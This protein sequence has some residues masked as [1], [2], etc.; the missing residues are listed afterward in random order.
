MTTT[1]ATGG[2]RRLARI[3]A[4]GI[5]ISLA[6]G[7]ARLLH[8]L[9]SGASAAIV[10]VGV[11]I[12]LRVALIY[13]SRSASSAT[14]AK[15]MR[16]VSNVGLAVSAVTVIAAVPH[17]TKHGGSG[18]FFSDAFGQLWALAVLTILAGPVRTIG[19][20]GLVGAGLAGFLAVTGL[21]RLVDRPLVNHFGVTS[22]F[23]V[24]GVVPVTEELFKLLP[25]LLVVLIAIRRT[26]VR[27]SVLDLVLLG[28][29]SGAGFTLFEDASLGRGGAQFGSFPPL[30]WLS[31]GGVHAKV[32]GSGYL[33]VGHLVH[34]ALIALGLG[35]W[36]LY[37]HRIR[38]AW[39]WLLLPIGAA[40]ADHMLNNAMSTGRLSHGTADP[41]LVLTLWGHLSLLLLLAG[42]G[43]LF[44]REGRS[45]GSLKPAKSWVQLTPE[46]AISRGK[47]LAVA[48]RSGNTIT[49]NPDGTVTVTAVDGTVTTTYPGGTSTVQGKDGS[50][51]LHK[52]GGQVINPDGSTD[53]DPSWKPPG[54]LEEDGGHAPG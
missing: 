30:S 45:I 51:T 12:G 39:A 48:Q 41:F 29:W 37:R 49:H 50:T 20:R 19:W 33:S 52:P 4:I 22:L 10:L 28:A 42:V 18:R 5:A 53:F 40:L 26:D 15:T 47:A 25:V 21:S 36:M 54:A 1:A 14:R 32:W 38:F 9:P 24:A 7:A 17:L 35:V 31:P 43:Y 13:A 2:D 23:T 46:V 8:V 6:A 16:M 11:V 34:T 3:A 44:V 27:P